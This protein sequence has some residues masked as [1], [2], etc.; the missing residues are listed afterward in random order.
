MINS[1]AVLPYYL[2]CILTSST[3]ISVKYTICTVVSVAG[4]FCM[5]CRV[6]VDA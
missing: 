1:D 2:I 3:Q 4:T 5:P 6:I